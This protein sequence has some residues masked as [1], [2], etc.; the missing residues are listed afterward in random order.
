MAAAAERERK[1]AAE[2]ARLEAAAAAAMR[3]QA[4]A[5]EVE[6]QHAE[7]M[8]IAEAAVAALSDFSTWTYERLRDTI[9]TST[10]LCKSSRD[11]KHRLA[12]GRFADVEILQA[13]RGE[14]HRRMRAYRQWKLTNAKNTR[15]N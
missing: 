5:A 8:A 3:E 14:F 11:Y 13:C 6:K 1:A 7:A 10:G 12:G 9:N 2:N 15:K 4:V